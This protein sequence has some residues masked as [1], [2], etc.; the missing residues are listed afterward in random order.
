MWDGEAV[1]PLLYGLLNVVSATG[2]VFAN[3][4]VLSNFGFSFT[5]ALTLIH[6]CTTLVGMMVFCR[7]GMFEVKAVPKRAVAPLAAA[8]VGYIVLCNLNLQLNTV[9]FYQ[10]TKIAV[11]PAVLVAEAVFFGKQ[12]SRRVVAAIVLVCLGVGLATITDTQ[13]GSSAAGLLAGL[14]AVCATA[15]YQIW[16]GTKQK[17]LGLGSMQLLHQ[18]CPIAAI[19][20]AILVPIFEPMG[21]EDRAPGTLLGYKF[22]VASVLAIAI[23]AVLGLLV[24]LST[25]LVIGATSSLTYNVVGHVKTA[26]ILAGGCIFFGDEMPPKKLAGIS[27]AMVGIIWYTQLK[28]SASS[29]PASP[30]KSTLPTHLYAKVPSRKELDQESQVTNGELGEA[31]KGGS[32]NNYLR[33]ASPRSVALHKANMLQKSGG[34]L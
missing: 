32:A 31:A 23:S 19:M 28:V 1:K 20:L 21:W 3:K 18:Y 27:V 30:R 5:Y 14:G 7:M 9:G 6:T 10:I 11:A 16:A 34:S 25:F 24:S 26:L 15:L 4:A 17:E 22:T 13:I 2:I 8:Y 12:A 33:R 29:V